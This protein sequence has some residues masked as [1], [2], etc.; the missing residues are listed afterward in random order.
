M[1]KVVKELSVPHKHQE[2][3]PTIIL[4]IIVCINQKLEIKMGLE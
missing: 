3:K 1:L 2:N 4:Q